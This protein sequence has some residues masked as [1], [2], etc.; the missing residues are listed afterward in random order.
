MTYSAADDITDCD[1]VRMLVKDISD[2]RVAKLRR[3]ID[4]MINRQQLYATVS[5]H[6]LYDNIIVTIGY[7]S[8][9][10]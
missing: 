5:R 2:L 8:H 1:Q 7:S 6:N 3:S 10:L 4:E 9:K